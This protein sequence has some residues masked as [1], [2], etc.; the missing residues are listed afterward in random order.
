MLQEL[1]LYAKQFSS[2]IN[3]TFTRTTIRITA[4]TGSAATDLGGET[5]HREFKLRTNKHHATID[6]IQAFDDTRLVI[7]DEVSFANYDSVLGKLSRH[8]Q[9]FTNCTQYQYGKMPIAFLGDFCQLET[10]G[11]NCIYKHPNGLYFEQA[12]TNMVELKGTHRYKDCEDMKTIMPEVREGRFSDAHRAILNSRVINGNSVKMPNLGTTRCATYFNKN[13]C[14]IHA[15]VFKKYLHTYHKECDENSIPRTAIVIRAGAQWKNSKRKLSHGHRKVL[16]EECDESDCS[17]SNNKHCDPL[18]CLYAGCHVM[19]NK[20]DD[21]AN[22]I[23]N[24]TT[25]KFRR[26]AFKQGKRP[27]PIKLHG[28]WVYATDAE[29]V[30]YI[31]LEWYDSLFIGRFKAKPCSQCWTVKY[32]ITECGRKMRVRTKIQLHQ[33]PVVLNLATTG[34]KLQGKSMDELVIAQWSKMKNWAY[35]VLS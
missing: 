19:G 16:Y 5:T 29:D 21:V 8:L 6:E 1:V 2:E 4:L 20:N 24:G 32:P 11:G 23:A 9:L 15:A 3:H 27:T 35:V 22:G 14:E 28:Y 33:F 12:L 17:D 31:E 7:V 26:I 25:S 18:L 10:I 13:R 30:E 34:H